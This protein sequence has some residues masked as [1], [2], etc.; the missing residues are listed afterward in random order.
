LIVDVRYNS[1]GD[2]S[3]VP[4]FIKQIIKRDR[5]D[6]P[7]NLFVIS[8]RKTFSAAVDFVAESKA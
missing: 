3:K 4:A 8:G 5:F 1:G 7:G 6:A 2:G